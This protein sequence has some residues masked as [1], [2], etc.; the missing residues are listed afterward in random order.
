[1]RW[2]REENEMRKEEKTTVTMRWKTS[3][4]GDWDKTR[5]EKRSREE[6]ETEQVETDKKQRDDKKVKTFAYNPTWGN[7]LNG[8]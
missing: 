8:A 7:V 6:K 4:H 5:R 2:K 1:M 3:W